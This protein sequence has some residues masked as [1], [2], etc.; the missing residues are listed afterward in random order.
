[1]DVI[2]GAG[3]TIRIGG[4]S[5]VVPLGVRAFRGRGR[6]Y[7]YYQSLILYSWKILLID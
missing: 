5:A 1:M 2:H 6:G 3:K 4:T 7:L